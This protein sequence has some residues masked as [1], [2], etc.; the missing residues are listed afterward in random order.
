ML[1]IEYSCLLDNDENKCKPMR[2]NTS[3][4]KKTI[5]SISNSKAFASIDTKKQTPKCEGKLGL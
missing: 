5:L 4:E 3:Y 1:C 2:S